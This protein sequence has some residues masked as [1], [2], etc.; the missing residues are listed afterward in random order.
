MFPIGWNG[1]VGDLC[2]VDLRQVMSGAAAAAA[3]F[4]AAG[5]DEAAHQAFVDAALRQAAVEMGDKTN[6]I[7]FNGENHAE[8]ETSVTFHIKAKGLGKVLTKA[9]PTDAVEAG[10]W[11]DLNDQAFGKIGERIDPKYHEFLL[12]LT[13]A[14][15]AMDKMKEIAEANDTNLLIRTRRCGQK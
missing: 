13:T 10:K 11:D 1:P 15:E 3:G 5:L 14:K 2:A 8:W 6:V 7:I 12:D 4:N 9:R